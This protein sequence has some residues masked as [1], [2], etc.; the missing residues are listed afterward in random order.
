MKALSFGW[1][2]LPIAIL[3]FGVGLS[4]CAA[5]ATARR[6][7]Q[8]TSTL[9]DDGAVVVERA[10]VNLRGY[11]LQGLV[12]FAMTNRPSLA[13]SRLAVKD[14][15]LRLKELAAEAPVF[16]DWDKPLDWFDASLSGGYDAAG[17]AGHDI[18]WQFGSEGNA[19]AALSVDLLIWD[20]GRYDAAARA[21]IERILAAELDLRNA[22]FAVFGEVTSAYFA[23]L[24][25]DAMLAVAKTNEFEFAQHLERIERLKDAGEAKALD[26]LRARLD[27]AQARERTVNATKEV[28]TA[29]AELLCA[30]GVEA[31]RGGREDVV[32]ISQNAL[33]FAKQG[34]ADTDYSVDVAF[35]FARTNAPAMRIA[36]ARLRA[37]SYDLDRAI[38]E[39]KPE[40]TL[41]ASFSWTDPLWIFRWGVRGVEQLLD[42]WRRATNIE[43]MSVALESA[44]A[45]VRDEEQQ[46]SLSLELAIAVRDNARESL[47]TAIES[48]RQAKANLEMV[49]RQYELGEANRVDYTD[50]VSAYVNALGNTV[51]AFYT[52]QTAEAALF[53]LVGRQPV[54]VEKLIKKEK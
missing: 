49:T 5:V 22:E 13:T 52:R 14:A 35:D 26:I 12:A 2:G 43:R 24:D 32:E 23:L 38:A 7:Q 17:K 15:R 29:G 45:M 40:L 30:L 27:L 31:S 54:Y 28:Q 10:K 41:S 1:W 33:A 51:T 48:L 20:W 53:K 6:V 21:Q 36:R 4:G 34:F 9:G 25:R 44:A 11:S 18:D 16:Y 19:S 37:A 50:A 46:L 8:E 39:L 3:A 42:S 47:I